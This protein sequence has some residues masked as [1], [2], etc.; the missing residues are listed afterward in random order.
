[1]KSPNNKVSTRHLSTSSENSGAR[2]ELHI[3]ELLVKENPM[4]TSK[5]LRLLPRLP[6][7]FHKLTVRPYY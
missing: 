3:I 4:G 1:M 2:K 7:S 5:Q 6:V